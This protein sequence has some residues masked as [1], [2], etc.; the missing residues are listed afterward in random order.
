MGYNQNAGLMHFIKAQREIVDGDRAAVRLV[1]R[2]E[3]FRNANGISIGQYIADRAPLFYRSVDD[4]LRD[5]QAGY[6]VTAIKSTLA[7]LPTSESFQESHFGEI[8]AGLFA[9]DVLGLRKLYS[10]LSLLSAENANAYKMDLVMYDPS[11]KPL[12]F[13]FGEVK[14]SPKISADCTPVGHDASCY[15]DIFNSMNKYSSEDCAFDLNAARDRLVGLKPGERE[16]VRQALLPYSGAR[17]AYA[18]F[19][20][21]DTSTYDKD[22][23]Q[24]LRTRK[25]DKQFEVDLICLESFSTIAGLVYGGLKGILQAQEVST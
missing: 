4:I 20:V 13:V 22:E 11:S 19:A 12:R 17:V 5:L 2:S 18:G 3:F 15:A 23:A 10:K 9:E 16:A 8:V 1:Y 6:F 24:V 7:K 25:N 21:I 14:C